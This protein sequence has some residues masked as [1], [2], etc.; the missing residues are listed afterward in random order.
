V[1]DFP[2]LIVQLAPYMAI[3]AEPVESG[4]AALREAQA[5]VSRDLANVGTTVITDLGEETDIHPT[6]KKPVGERLALAAR[7]LAYG[8][9]IVAFGPTFRSASIDKG[10]LLL[11]FDNVG[12]GLTVHGDR[13]TGFAIAGADEKFVNA[14]ASLV[15]NR[16]V[17][18]SPKVAS[19]AYVRFGWADYPVVNL[20]NADGLPATPFRSDPP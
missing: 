9:K 3:Q 7:K 19:P 13:L 18:S 20:W 2:F 1:G 10:K 17:V 5:Q 4:W 8:E 12:K 11:S 6:R 14:E 15:G 16:V